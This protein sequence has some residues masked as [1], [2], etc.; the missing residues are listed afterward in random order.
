M[1]ILGNMNKKSVKFGLVLFFVFIS[2][3]LVTIISAE[4]QQE[5]KARLEQEL[6]DLQAQ[7]SQIDNGTWVKIEV[8]I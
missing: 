8:I 2:I 7:L 4:T 5:E 1:K 3:L 6:A